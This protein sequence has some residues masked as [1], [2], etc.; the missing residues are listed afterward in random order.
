[1][2][3]RWFA[4][5]AVLE[6]EVR[7]GSDEERVDLLLDPHGRRAHRLDVA[8]VAVDDQE[9]L[10]AVRLQARHHLHQHL[11]EGVDRE[12]GIVPGKFMW[13]NDTPH[14]IGGATSRRG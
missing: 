11:H 14:G 2:P 7:A 1:M 8:A 9:A 12:G 6:G 5:G 10:E 13:W 3:W 4:A